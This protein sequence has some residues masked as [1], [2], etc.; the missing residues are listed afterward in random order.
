MHPP[1]HATGI[2]S[3]A[4]LIGSVDSHAVKYVAETRAQEGR[5]EEILDLREMCLVRL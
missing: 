1:P 2:P 5:K 3:Y 4:S